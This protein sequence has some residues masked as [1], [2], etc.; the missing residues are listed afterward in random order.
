MNYKRIILIASVSLWLV[1]LHIYRVSH[2]GGFWRD[3]ISSIQVAL[4]QNWKSLYNTQADDS[5]PLLNVTC[6]RIWNNIFNSSERTISQADFIIRLYGMIAGLFLAWCVLTSRISKNSS[7]RQFS[8]TLF[9]ISPVVIIWGDSL[10]AYALGTAL[11]V[12]FLGNIFEISINKILKKKYVIKSIILGILAVWALYG[13]AFLILA[14]CMGGAAYPLLNCEWKK[15]VVIISI[16]LLAGMSML[17][18][19]PT[20]NKLIEIKDI[21][22]HYISLKTII[23]TLIKSIS[24]GG[25]RFLYLWAL[26]FSILFYIT[27][28]IIFWETLSKENEFIKRKAFFIF[29]TSVS[30]AVLFI[31]YIKCVDQYPQDWYYIPLCAL[32]VCLIDAAVTLYK[33]NPKLLKAGLTITILIILSSA[34][35][36]LDKLSIKMTNVDSVASEL[37]LVCRKNDLILISDQYNASTFLHY[38]KGFSDVQIYPP[39]S[40]YEMASSSRIPILSAIKDGDNAIAPLLNK[41]KNTLQSG[42]TVWYVGDPSVFP[43]NSV[44]SIPP[45]VIFQGVWKPGPFLYCWGAQTVNYLAINAAEI[46]RFKEFDVDKTSALEA[47]KNVWGFRGWKA[48]E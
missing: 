12:L 31:V 10:R 48:M 36:T 9:A 45:N 20:I 35:N 14:I 33:P 6:I 44:P 37:E 15:V 11:I 40:R 24:A 23:Y 46:F 25:V 17:L 39:C 13:N 7:F 41:I 47:T 16:G 4:S 27:I 42:G 43:L 32:Q 29:I 1:F 3:E 2:A 38:Y 21:A 22:A 26:G 5:F 30:S 34:P 18:N 8:W 28:Y 19:I